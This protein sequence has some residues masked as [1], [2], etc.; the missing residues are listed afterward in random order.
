MKTLFCL[1]I[2]VSLLAAQQNNPKLNDLSVSNAIGGP[3][4]LNIVKNAKTITA[5]R[6][7]SKIAETEEQAVKHPELIIVDQPVN[8]TGPE[9]EDVRKA[10]TTSA[11][12]LSPSKT[13]IFRANVRYAFILSPEQ[14]VEFVLCFGCGELEVWH[15]GQMVS[16]GPFDGGYANLLDVTKRIFPRDEFIAAF[17]PKTFE[18]RA[19]RMREMTP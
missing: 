18:Q 15:K 9:A 8:V 5:Q 1:L 13:C 3:E 10:F 6:V 4:I 16:F 17:D 12:Y 14:K 2:S 11:T 7:D 19:A